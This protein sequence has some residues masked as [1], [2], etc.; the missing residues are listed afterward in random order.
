MKKVLDDLVA[1]AS[2]S[3]QDMGA[4]ERKIYAAANALKATLLQLWLDEAE[5]DSSHPFCPHCGKPLRQK[6]Q[7]CK[8]CICEGG[9][10]QVARKRWW[11]AGC[12]VSF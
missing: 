4:M 9:Q 12:G 3:R 7:V 8:T 11:C 1:E 10:V 6:Q 5:D 2:S